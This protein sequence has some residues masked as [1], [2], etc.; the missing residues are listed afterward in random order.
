[1]SCDQPTTKIASGGD[2]LGRVHVLGLDHR[3]AEVVERALAGAV[4]IDR[5]RQGDDRDD[6]RARFGTR[7]EATAPDHV[8][9]DPDGSHSSALGNGQV[10]GERLERALIRPG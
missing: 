10:F 6:L 8:E 1:M 9:A 5:P 4:G 3:H 7:L 2:C